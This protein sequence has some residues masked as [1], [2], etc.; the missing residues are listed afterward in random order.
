M[1]TSI[2]TTGLPI[3]AIEY[4]AI[5]ICGQGNNDAV[6]SAAFASFVKDWLIEKKILPA[7]STLNYLKMSPEEKGQFIDQY[8]DEFLNETFPG[9]DTQDVH[10]QSILQLMTTSNPSSL[11]SAEITVDGGYDPCASG[12]NNKKR[13]K[14][15]TTNIPQPTC[16]TGFNYHVNL[17]FCYKILHPSQTDDHGMDWCY[18]HE[19]EPM[20]FWGDYEIEA[21]V[22]LANNG[23]AKKLLMCIPSTV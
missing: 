9:M 2:R 14:R 3:S 18:D 5:V 17:G 22:D 6:V 23:N 7:N 10:P 12:T 4:P 20:I 21:F 11:I 8:M 16:P 13:K 15:Q 19:S 1:L